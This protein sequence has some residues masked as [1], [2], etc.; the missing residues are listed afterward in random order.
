MYIQ[1]RVGEKEVEKS[2]EDL[3]GLTHTFM[4]KEPIW[5]EAWKTPWQPDHMPVGSRVRIQ[6]GEL[7]FN[8][9]W[10]AV[11]T[12]HIRN[13]ARSWVIKTDQPCEA[14]KTETG[15]SMHYSHVRQVLERGTGGVVWCENE[16]IKNESKRKPLTGLQYNVSQKRKSEYFA[17]TLYDLLHTIMNHHPAFAYINSD[18]HL[19]Y[20]FDHIRELEKMGRWVYGDIRGF[21]VNKKKFNKALHAAF[22]K[23]RS[24]RKAAQWREDEEMRRI[25][26]DD[27]RREMEREAYAH[28]DD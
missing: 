20:I 8:K 19:Y 27:M 11:V 28:D 17:E 18:N 24:N 12:G 10:E 9:P 26:E 1:V 21:V 25:Y 13:G 3:D 22:R 5:G 2:Y 7:P 16:Y 15:R 23:S 4:D 6:V 14:L